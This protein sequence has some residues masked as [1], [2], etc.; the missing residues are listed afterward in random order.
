MH[1]IKKMKWLPSSCSRSGVRGQVQYKHG[2]HYGA[3]MG[4]SGRYK[5]G[6]DV[7]T[8]HHKC[9]LSPTSTWQY[10]ALKH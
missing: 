9:C 3:C 7:S 10:V 5:E 2:N 4:V 6:T 1:Q 8:L